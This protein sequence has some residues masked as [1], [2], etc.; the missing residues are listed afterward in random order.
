M[1][2]GD[3]IEDDDQISKLT[4]EEAEQIIEEKWKERMNMERNHR[5]RR[6]NKMVSMFRHKA[7][8]ATYSGWK[9]HT[10][11]KKAERANHL[12]STKFFIHNMMH[13]NLLLR[14][15]H[16]RD[17]HKQRQKMRKFISR[18]IGGKKYRMIDYAF[19]MLKKHSVEE[20][21]REGR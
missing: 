10:K 15:N 14:F 5:L 9:T 16:W 19:R 3:L 8:Y 6:M 7:L 20:E 4:P 12:K 17:Y 18:F 13:N 1:I 11:Q 21:M 2:T